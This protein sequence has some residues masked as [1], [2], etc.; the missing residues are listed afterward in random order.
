MVRE[1]YEVA[2]LEGELDLFGKFALAVGAADPA[3]QQ[4]RID[5][6]RDEMDPFLRG[7]CGVGDSAI[8]GALDLV[9]ETERSEPPVSVCYG[10]SRLIQ[11][12]HRGEGSI[13]ADTC[14]R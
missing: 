3:V 2:R 5:E 12:V 10:G 7:S 14:R 6:I 9:N 11:E 1:W 13:K 8:E 4:R